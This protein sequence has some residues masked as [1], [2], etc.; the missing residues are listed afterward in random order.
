M[1]GLDLCYG[2]W[3]TNQHSIADV[4]PTDINLTVFPGQDYNNAR[5]MDFQ[6][7]GEWEKNELDITTSARMGWSDVSLSLTG[8]A[9]QSLMTHFVERWNFIF[10]EKYYTRTDVR[11]ASLPMPENIRP[12]LEGKFQGSARCQI[13]R[14]CA[15]W[16]HGSTI[17]ACHQV[18]ILVLSTDLTALQHSIADAYIEAVRNSQHFIYIENQFFITATCDKQRP[19]QNKIGA[20]MV[21]RILRAARAGQRYKIF[22]TIPAVPAFAGDLREDDSLSTRAIMEF[23]Y[24][25]I[26][27]GGYSIMETIANEGFDPTEYIR[28][29]NLRFVTK[30]MMELNRFRQTDAI[31]EIMTD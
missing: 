11:Y 29:Y 17:E 14:S 3:D 19:I 7:V 25:S 31:I 12:P 10:R 27:R 2:R 8:P 23:Q 30:R 15:K 4:H 22:I 5:I 18:P 1:G 24:N 20:A 28:F 16:S 13:L 21:E 6:H 9:V 26:N